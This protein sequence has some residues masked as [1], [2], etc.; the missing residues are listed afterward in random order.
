MALASGDVNAQIWNNLGLGSALTQ[1]YRFREADVA[2]R[3]GLDAARRTG[4]ATSIRRL[5]EAVG[6]VSM[7][8]GEDA[9]AAET[10]E[11]AVAM[12]GVDVS[13]LPLI[14]LSGIYRRLGRLDDALAAATRG[15]ELTRKRGLVDNELR[16][17]IELA[18]VQEAQADLDAAQHTL[19]GV[20][21]RLESYRAELAPQDFLK[22]GFGSRFSD[23]YG[24][25]VHLLMRRDRPAEALTAAERVRSRAFADLLATRRSREIE[26]AETASGAWRLGG[27]T[28]HAPIA[29]PGSDSAR[30]LPALDS[31]ALAALARRLSTTLVVYWINDRGS[32]AWVVRAEG[33]IHAAALEATPADL[34]RAVRNASDTVAEAA[35][36]RS[37]ASRATAV[38]GNRTA[39]RTLHRLV[40]APIDPLVA[41]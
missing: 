15:L 12:P 16:V 32:Y 22:Q 29:S 7:M 11:Q 6:W 14:H 26:E 2:M 10:L 41:Q 9:R 33:A 28:T 17:L 36:E 38:V 31:T 30:V 27:P 4:T 20:V 37:S 35:I 21:D 40:W 3:R 1:L 13:V 8:R 19:Q 23:A 24:A 34:A 25:S 18:Q 5:T 39:Y